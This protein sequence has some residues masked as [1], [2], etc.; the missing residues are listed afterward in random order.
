MVLEVFAIA[1]DEDERLEPARSLTVFAHER[2]A[3][4]MLLLFRPSS[5]G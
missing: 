2:A 5:P 3:L 1:G 4:E